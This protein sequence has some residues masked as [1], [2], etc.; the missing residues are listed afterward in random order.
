MLDQLQQRG[1]ARWP[2]QHGQLVDAAKLGMVCSEQSAP[3]ILPKNRG[4]SQGAHELRARAGGA[5]CIRSSD[6]WPDTQH[7]NL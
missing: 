5:S 4:A 2:E 6:E 1:I 3:I 7:A